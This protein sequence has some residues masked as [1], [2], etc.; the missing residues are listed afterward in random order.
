ML[1]IDKFKD[2]NDTHG[3]SVGDDIILCIVRN[4]NTLVRES[5]VVARYGGEEF[6][7]LL[8]ETDLEGACKMSEKIREAIEKDMH[9]AKGKE[10]GFTASFGVSEVDLNEDSSIMMALERAD[11][12]LYQAKAKGRNVVV[13]N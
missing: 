7:L 1:D 2:I 6:V 5:D 11:D 8:P 12:G 9:C 3:H 4:L 10:I 13:C